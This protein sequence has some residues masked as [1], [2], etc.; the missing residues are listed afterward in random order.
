MIPQHDFLAMTRS[1]E[2]QLDPFE[3]AL[4][5][6]ARVSVWDTGVLCLEPA[7]GAGGPAGRAQ[8]YR[9]LLRHPRQRDC[10]HR[11]LPTSC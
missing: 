3:F 10:P 5:D 4:P 8:G 6:G 1:H 11:D 2:W 9:P 7:S